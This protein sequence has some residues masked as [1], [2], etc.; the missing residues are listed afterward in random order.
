MRGYK[1][2]ISMDNQDTNPALNN[3]Q[4]PTQE[5]SPT[6]TPV[7]PEIPVDDTSQVDEKRS[8]QG[9]IREVVAEKNQYKEKLTGITEKLEQLTGDQLNQA[10]G[11]APQ[12]TPDEKGEVTAEQVYAESQRRAATTTFLINQQQ[13]AVD[14]IRVETTELERQYPELNPDSDK[15][16]KDLS[17]AIATAVESQAKILTGYDQA[18]K[19]IYAINVGCSPKAIVTK[20]MKPY[21]K[22]LNTATAQAEQTTREDIS[23]TALRPTPQ[24]SAPEKKAEDMSI[25]ELRKKLGVVY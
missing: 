18:G 1:L 23:K 21:R 19:P 4:V 6:Q 10:I 12:A 2:N 14:R 7:P 20:L 3:E 17:E 8:A 5:Q 16:D 24:V 13:R 15:Y 25:E 22:S 11:M 9:R